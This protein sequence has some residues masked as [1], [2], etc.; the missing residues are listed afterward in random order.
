VVRLLD[1]YQ[2]PAKL[3]FVMELATGTHYYIYCYIHH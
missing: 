1:Y 3:Y 2:T